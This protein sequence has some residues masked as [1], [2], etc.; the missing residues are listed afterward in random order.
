MR[1]VVIGARR[2]LVVMALSYRR[3]DVLLMWIDM[4]RGSG[5]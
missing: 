4:M 1:A 3:D 2:G 5:Q